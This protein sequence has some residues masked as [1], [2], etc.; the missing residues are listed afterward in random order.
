MWQ[1][2]FDTCSDVYTAL[3]WGEK[4]VLGS[5]VQNCIKVKIP[6]PTEQVLFYFL[7]GRPTPSLQTNSGTLRF[8][9]QM[10]DYCSAVWQPLL[11]ISFLHF[12]MKIILCT[13]K[14]LCKQISVSLYNVLKL[15]SLGQKENKASFA[16]K[17]E[18]KRNMPHPKMTRSEGTDAFPAACIPSPLQRS[19]FPWL[20]LSEAAPFGPLGH[21]EPCRCPRCARGLWA[22]RQW[23]RREHSLPPVCPWTCRTQSSHTPCRRVQST[24]NSLAMAEELSGEH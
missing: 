22:P 19:N 11:S 13:Y 9:A 14:K 4:L 20:L 18:E 7:Q 12:P 10:L 5:R 23:A 17:L 2:W 16:I 6:S 1:Q 15:I 24:Q 21:R 8:S 3:R